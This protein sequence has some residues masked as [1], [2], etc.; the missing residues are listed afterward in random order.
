MLFRKGDTDQIK[1]ATSIT[2]EHGT[3]INNVEIH[4]PLS[5]RICAYFLFRK[6]MGHWREGMGKE[7]YCK[8]GCLKVCYKQDI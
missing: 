6:W 4:Y 8:F 3:L 1:T 5:P 7:A 2:P